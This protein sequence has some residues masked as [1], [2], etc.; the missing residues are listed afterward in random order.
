MDDK[1]RLQVNISENTFRNIKVLAAQQGKS[2]SYF[3]ELGLD[4]I[5]SEYNSKKN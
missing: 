2:M 5:V 1:K 3:V 4:K